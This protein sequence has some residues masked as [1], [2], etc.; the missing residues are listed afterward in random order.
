MGSNRPFD[1]SDAVRE[2]ARLRQFGLCAVCGMSLNDQWEEAHHVV[3]NQTGDPDNANHA[4]LRTV[5]NCVALCDTCHDQV[6]GHNKT[7]GAV[8]P[9]EYYEYSH[10]PNRVQHQAWV[11]DL[12]NTAQLLWGTLPSRIHSV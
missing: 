1:F 9:P 11:N 5:I 8:A 2:Q 3:P 6:H 7:T 4:W 10:G 12:N